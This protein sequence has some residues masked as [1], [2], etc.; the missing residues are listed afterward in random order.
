M[1]GLEQVISTLNS[2]G[3][4]AELW[5]DGSFMTKKVNPQD[6]DIVIRVSAPYVDNGP[7]EVQTAVDWA[8]QNLKATLMCDSYV[9]PVY[10]TGHPDYSLGRNLDAFWKGQFGF[11]R[12]SNPKGIAVVTLN[13][14][15]Q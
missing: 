15:V 12:A 6:V 3:L 8:K 13:G 4:Q 14:G 9:L 1:R 7:P 10:P 2:A 5:V 11:S